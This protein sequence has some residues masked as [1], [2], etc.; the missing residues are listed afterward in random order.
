[1]ALRQTDGPT[2]RCLKR[3]CEEDLASSGEIICGWDDDDDDYED[4]ESSGDLLVG[5]GDENLSEDDVSA[6]T[7][8]IKLGLDDEAM[9]TAGDPSA[10]IVAAHTGFH[11]SHDSS[12]IVHNLNVPP[13]QVAVEIPITRKT[14]KNKRKGSKNKDKDEE[15]VKFS[16]TPVETTVTSSIPTQK[17][18]AFR[19][20][21]YEKKKN[22]QYK[23]KNKHFDNE[24]GSVATLER[25]Q[26]VAKKKRALK[27]EFVQG[28]CVLAPGKGREIGLTMA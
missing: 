25:A 10:T 8:E 7:T 26:K 23:K 9:P 20:S 13:P 4:M 21:F 28:L 2:T 3:L 17:N 22:H 18:I 27:N 15:S 24:D 11:I 5:W 12:H 6:K 16:F 1:M 19:Q 14:K